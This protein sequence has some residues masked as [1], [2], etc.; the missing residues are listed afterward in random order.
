[1]AALLDERTFLIYQI[2]LR[3]YKKSFLSTQCDQYTTC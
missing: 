1:M 3:D 2:P